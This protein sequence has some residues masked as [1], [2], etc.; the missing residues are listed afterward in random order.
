MDQVDGIGEVAQV[1][2]NFVRKS[3]HGA[4]LPVIE[5]ENHGRCRIDH[6]DG[7]EL[8]DCVDGGKGVVMKIM[9]DSPVGEQHSGRRKYLQ[10]IDE[11]T[12]PFDSLHEGREFLG[13]KG[14]E[15]EDEQ[16]MK[17]DPIQTVVK[18]VLQDLTCSREGPYIAGIEVKNQ[19]ACEEN[20]KTVHRTLH[21]EA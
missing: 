1:R 4:A 17:D 18:G 7:A 8:V 16:I 10:D 15:H 12:E 5:K 3:S 20:R 14:T 13:R 2:E 19:I 21:H 11:C 6:A 9:H